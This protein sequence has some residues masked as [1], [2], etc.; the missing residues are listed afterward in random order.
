MGN[1]TVLEFSELSL[2]HN[3]LYYINM[4]LM[5]GLGFT[6]VAS[7]TPFLVDFTPPTPGHLR[8]AIS[9]TMEFVPCEELSV[10]GLLCIDHITQENHR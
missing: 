5:N 8:S 6:S 2:E 10:G 3:T 1:S 4:R 9:D 7:S